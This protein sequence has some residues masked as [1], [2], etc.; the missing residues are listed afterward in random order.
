MSNKAYDILSKVQRW[1]PAFGTF[2]LGL[3]QVWGLPM[4]NEVNETIALVATLLAATLEISTVGYHKKL[5]G[6]I[7]IASVLE[8]DEEDEVGGIG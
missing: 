6:E 1:L 4:G 3:C 8:E 7:D 5:Q 2:Y